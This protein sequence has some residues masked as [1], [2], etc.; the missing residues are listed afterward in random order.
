[1]LAGSLPLR[2]GVIKDKNTN[3]ELGMQL[4]RPLILLKRDLQR[5]LALSIAESSQFLL[6]TVLVSHFILLRPF[7]KVKDA[8]IPLIM[9]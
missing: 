1:M 2:D 8:G 6:E 4:R 5:H 3:S 7:D 9:L